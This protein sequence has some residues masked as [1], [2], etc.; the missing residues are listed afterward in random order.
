MTQMHYYDVFNGDADGICALHQ[1]R[2]ADP[3]DSVLVTGLKHEIALLER[4]LAR[5]GDVVTV[6]DVSLDRNRQALLLLLEQGVHVRYFDHH[7]AGLI[8]PNR[9]LEPIIDA[10][11]TTCTSALV[12][13]QLGGRY[14][15]WAVVGAFGDG[16]IELAGR[17]AAPLGLDAGALG[18]LRDLG[19]TLNYNAYGATPADVALPPKAVYRLVHQYEDPFELMRCEPVIGGI[20]RQR[21][22][23]L[24]NAMGVAA[25]RRGEWGDAYVLP[26]ATWSRRVSGEFANRLAMAAPYKA[27]AVITPLGGGL[28]G[29]SV[30]S[31]RGG[32]PLA[33]DFCRAFPTGGGRREAAGIERIAQ[34]DLDRFLEA[35]EA[36]WDSLHATV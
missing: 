27:H 17:L 21:R 20:A 11:G 25:L 35:F 5:P 23:D 13:R 22:V 3:L 9:D 1:L 33:V 6:L 31:P 12:D 24:E 10:A 16:L 8:P 36:A 26:D 28:F 29:A 14:R 2:L 15:V 19:N 32:T 30:R 7:Y 4:V 18:Q 34:R